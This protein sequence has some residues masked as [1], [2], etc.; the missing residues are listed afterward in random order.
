MKT[1]NVMDGKRRWPFL[2]GLDLSFVHGYSIGTNNESKERQFIRTK[3]TFAN[4]KVEF[5]LAK[6]GQH[7]ARVKKVGIK[8]GAIN[9]DV[10]EVDD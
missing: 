5:V 6:S 7:R 1:L 4:A 2:N 8:V 10:V 3:D 9:E